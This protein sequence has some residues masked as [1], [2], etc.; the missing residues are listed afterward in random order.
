MTSLQPTGPKRVYDGSGDTQPSKRKKIEEIE[1][2]DRLVIL[3]WDIFYQQ[4]FPRI[5]FKTLLHF[6][7][8]SR[9]NYALADHQWEILRQQA[10][11]TVDWNC[12]TG[13]ASNYFL[14][15]NVI[16]YIMSLKTR[17]ALFDEQNLKKFQPVCDEIPAFNALVQLTKLKAKETISPKIA[18]C[19]RQEKVSD[20]ILDIYQFARTIHPL[21]TTKATKA[22]KAQKQNLIKEFEEQTKPKIEK[23]IQEGATYIS[24]VTMHIFTRYLLIG[25]RFNQE[26]RQF[27]S[28][29]VLDLSIKAKDA[30]D[31]SSWEKWKELKMHLSNYITDNRFETDFEFLRDKFI[32]LQDQG[33]LKFKHWLWL[34]DINKRFKEDGE[35]EQSLIEQKAVWEKLGNF[36]DKVASDPELLCAL[37][38]FH[39]QSQNWVEADSLS[40]TIMGISKGHMRLPVLRITAKIKVQLNRLN[41]AV[42]IYDLLLKQKDFKEIRNRWFAIFE[43]TFTLKYQLLD[44]VGADDIMTKIMEEA[45]TATIHPGIPFMQ[46]FRCSDKQYQQFIHVKR[47]LNKEKEA[48]EL[49]ILNFL[50]H[51]GTYDDQAIGVYEAIDQLFQ[52]TALQF[53]STLSLTPL[54]QMAEICINQKRYDRAEFLFN[55]IQQRYHIEHWNLGQKDMFISAKIELKQ[56]QEAYDLW[57]KSNPFRST[58]FLAW[59]D[60]RIREELIKEQES[61]KS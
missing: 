32:T 29:I 58:H 43:E 28:K 30:G 51:Q 61:D 53:V 4:L 5:S 33:S 16:S 11:F 55:L 44:W 26:H 52:T 3:P 21:N 39:V 2:V 18:A 45:K 48:K 20:A 59:Q 24:L 56:W 23:L 15:Q 19:L 49:E 54:F 36:P 40:T 60:D 22:D 12:C 27:A 46:G 35:D 38:K 1:K 47:Q 10:H 50:E 31:D 25:T 13:N 8:T 17:L 6:G 42:Q 34:S 7:L 37:F 9:K 14:S 57:K 41:E